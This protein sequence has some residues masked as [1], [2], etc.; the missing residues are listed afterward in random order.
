[1]KKIKETAEFEY[2]AVSVSGRSGQAVA[3][4]KCLECGESNLDPKYQYCPMCGRMFEVI[5]TQL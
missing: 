4:M 2:Y 3:K 1:M 5:E